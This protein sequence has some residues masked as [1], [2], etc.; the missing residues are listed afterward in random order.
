MPEAQVKRLSFEVGQLADPGREVELGVDQWV[1]PRRGLSDRGVRS[2][3]ATH[4]RC[5]APVLGG[6]EEREPPRACSRRAASSTAPA[7]S[8]GPAETQPGGVAAAVAQT[9][10]KDRGHRKLGGRRW[11]RQRLGAGYSWPPGSRVDTSEVPAVLPTLSRIDPTPRPPGPNYPP[12]NPSGADPELQPG[13]SLSP[14]RP[15]P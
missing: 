3:R 7:R 9:A 15:D 6:R 2:S 1:A 10:A 11:V 14:Y 8:R 4:S 5:S 12:I 13:S